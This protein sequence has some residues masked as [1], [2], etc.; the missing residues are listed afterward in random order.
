[1]QKPGP[2]KHHRQTRFNSR[3]TTTSHQSLADSARPPQL[4]T[5]R[6]GSD[7]RASLHPGI[8]THRDDVIARPSCAGPR[9]IL[10]PNDL[11]S[12]VSFATAIARPERPN[13]ASGAKAGL[14][15]SF[16]SGISE[17]PSSLRLSSARVHRYHEPHLYERSIRGHVQHSRLRILAKKTRH[18]TRLPIPQTLSSASAVWSPRGAASCSRRRTTCFL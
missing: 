10:C 2:P 6:Q 1:M 7:C 13:Q 15:S 3:H 11:G 8:A 12:D 16:G 14:L 18:A 9:R 4:A 17:N 5:P